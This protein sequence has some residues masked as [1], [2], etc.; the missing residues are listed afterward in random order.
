MW[1]AVIH[2]EAL[3]NHVLI[4]IQIIILRKHKKAMQDIW[5]E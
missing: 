4:F 3:Q 2:I 1:S 5:V